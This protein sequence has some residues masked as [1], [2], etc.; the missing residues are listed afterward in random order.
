[1][2]KNSLQVAQRGTG[3]K[4]CVGNLSDDLRLDVDNHALCLQTRESKHIIYIGDV[5]QSMTLR[6]TAFHEAKQTTAR[7]GKR[8][9]EKE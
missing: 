5:D 4:S 2:N 9:R 3:K 8:E 7:E 6:Y 1:M